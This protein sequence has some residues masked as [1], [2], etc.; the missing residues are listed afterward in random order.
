MQPFP[1]SGIKLDFNFKFK[2][3]PKR[4]SVSRLN[5]S[6]NLALL[7]TL[8]RTF[9]GLSQS[10]CRPNMAAVGTSRSHWVRLYVHEPML[11]ECVVALLPLELGSVCGVHTIL[12]TNPH[13]T[14]T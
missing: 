14:Y 11:Q 2:M 4:C 5:V 7:F 1:F 9:S 3:C 8:Q 12:H 6:D 13:N 10:S